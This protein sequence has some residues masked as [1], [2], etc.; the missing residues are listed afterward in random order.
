VA[1]IRISRANTTSST[2]APAGRQV[3]LADSLPKKLVERMLEELKAIPPILR[4]DEKERRL[5]AYLDA[6]YGDCVLREPEVAAMVQESLLHFAGSRYTLHAWCIM[7]NHVHIL[8]QPANDI[9]MSTS[10]ASWKKYT[11]R[12]ISEWR[13]R[14][15]GVPPGPVWHRE[16]FDRYMR[17]DDHYRNAVE[18]IHQNPVKAKLV[19]R[20]EEWEWSSGVS[21]RHPAC[22]NPQ[23]EHLSYSKRCMVF[24]PAVGRWQ[25]IGKM[26]VR[27]YT[28]PVRH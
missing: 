15:R 4:D 11:G 14:N 17:D 1:I 6:G 23:M 7:P 3:H 28:P 27:H 13:Q 5:N 12:R 2:S 9:T 18:Y 10:M 16:Y 26:P 8:M 25:D 24:A 22:A 20:A 21:H 19:A